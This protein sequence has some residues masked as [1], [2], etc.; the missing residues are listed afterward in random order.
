MKR[1]PIRSSETPTKDIPFS[2]K[3]QKFN[4]NVKGTIHYVGTFWC[5]TDL[6]KTYS[7]KGVKCNLMD[8]II[9]ES[10]FIDC[11]ENCPFAKERYL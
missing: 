4:K 1:N 9:D 7:K 5:K 6:Q 3:C 10:Y 2:G 8:E 11:L